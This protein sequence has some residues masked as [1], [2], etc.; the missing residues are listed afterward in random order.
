[1][2]HGEEELTVTSF[3]VLYLDLMDSWMSLHSVKLNSS[4]R[5]VTFQKSNQITEASH[6]IEASTGYT[7]QK[8]DYTV[9]VLF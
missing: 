7:L 1:M 9:H 5:L 3:S 8:A 2:L 4:L 6:K